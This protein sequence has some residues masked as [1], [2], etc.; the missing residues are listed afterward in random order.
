M[1]PAFSHVQR[2][3]AEYHPGCPQQ[4]AGIS[5]RIKRR[6]HAIAPANPRVTVGNEVTDVVPL[7]VGYKEVDYIDDRAERFRTLQRHLVQMAS[8]KQDSNDDNETDRSV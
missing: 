7:Q 4:R 6:Q 5:G 8:Q 1:G 3:A 2:L